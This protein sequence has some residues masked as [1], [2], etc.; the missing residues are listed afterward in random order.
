MYKVTPPVHYHVVDD[1]CA[2]PGLIDGMVLG[3]DDFPSQRRTMNA[4]LPLN[5]Q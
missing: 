2:V 4:F 1:F 3:Y 5:I